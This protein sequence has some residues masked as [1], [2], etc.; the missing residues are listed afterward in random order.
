[1]CDFFQRRAVIKQHEKESQKQDILQYHKINIDFFKWLTDQK[2]CTER[3]FEL[4]KQAND[5]SLFLDKQR[6][7][8]KSFFFFNDRNEDSL[9]VF[10]LTALYHRK[11]LCYS[12]F[13]QKKFKNR[14]CL[15]LSYLNLMI[16]HCGEKR[17]FHY[18]PCA[19][20]DAFIL[21]LFQIGNVSFLSQTSAFKCTSKC[22]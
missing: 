18:F 4:C 20:Y 8:F 19:L 7:V 14:V 11:F 5:I 22:R 21:K 6:L 10:F 3:C 1:M 9:S 15:A 17:I 16:T 2:K 12:Q 13:F